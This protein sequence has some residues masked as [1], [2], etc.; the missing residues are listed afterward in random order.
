MFL[1]SQ[2]AGTSDK[3]QWLAENGLL[4][5]QPHQVTLAGLPLKDG[6][7]SALGL[8]SNIF[9][10]VFLLRFFSLCFDNSFYF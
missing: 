10:L 1:N 6:T 5:L 3:L 8:F 7:P 4:P 2:G 9:C